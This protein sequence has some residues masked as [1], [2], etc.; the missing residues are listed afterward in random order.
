MVIG[1][2]WHGR[3]KTIVQHFTGYLAKMFILLGKIETANSIEC[4]H[5]QHGFLNFDAINRLVVGEVFF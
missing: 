4:L 2:C 3:Q 1:A 5:K